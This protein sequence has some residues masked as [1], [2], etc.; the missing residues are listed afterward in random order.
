MIRWPN[1]LQILGFFIL[2]LALST[3]IVTLFAFI[4]QDAGSSPLTL[5]TLTAGGLG[6]FLCLAFR[7]PPHEFTHREGLLLVI[8]TWVAAGIVGALPFYFSDYFPSF[9][10]ACFESISG[11]TTTG[12]TILGD[13]EAL[14]RSLLLWR[15]L[16]HWIGGMGIILLGIAILPLIGVGGMELYRAEF[17]GARS[18]KLTPRVAETALALWKVYLGFSL[19]EYLCLRW[20]G[21]DPFEAVCHTFST[22]ATGGFSTRNTSIEAFASPTIE[23]II[24]FFMI[25]AGINF[26]QHYRLLVERRPKSLF[27][28]AEVRFYFLL[29]AAVTTAVA[30]TLSPAS[31]NFVEAGRLALFQVVSILTTTGF[32][33]ANFEL[34]APFAQLL[35]LASMFAGGCTGSTA[36]GLKIARLYLLFRVVGRE[37]QRMVERRGIFAIRFNAEAV[38][39]NAIQSLLNLVYLA[40]LINFAAC[41]ALTALGVDV[42]TAIAAVAASMFNIGPGL[43][44][45]GP[46][47]N[48]AHLPFLAKWILGFCMLAG[49]LEYYTVLVLFTRAFW[50]K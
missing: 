31:E 16:T 7:P 24:I 9:T 6:A 17:S 50:R 35:L 22:M 43:G 1:L 48:Y 20:A 40:F 10:D 2:A 38:S 3:G 28:D 33:S 15:S 32:S 25:V 8:A 27:R 47:E 19:A 30:L 29:I 41:M 36:G 39:E 12:A 14:P 18:E 37:F 46:A 42:L 26:T 45:V 5:A 44:K 11:F 49:R 34:W 13:V 23:G 21:M 4:A